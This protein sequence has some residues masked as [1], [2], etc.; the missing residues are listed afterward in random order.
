[1]KYTLIKAIDVAGLTFLT[2]VVR[3]CYRE[4]PKKQ[5]K[6]IGRVI[7][8]PIAAFLVFLM[9]WGVVAPRH[10]TKSGEVPT[11][12][13]VWDAAD[14]IWRFH[15]REGSK[16]DAY[17]LSGK[18]REEKLAI[19]ESHL[20]KL[21]PM[22]DIVRK[23]VEDAESAQATQLAEALAPLVAR[24]DKLEAEFQS[25]RQKREAGLKLSLIHI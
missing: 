3:L 14:S 2:P 1:M 4:E 19:V 9:I 15:N 23:Q 5:M 20:T 8:V 25:A 12:G 16:E 21:R 22:E 24:Y 10:K 17:G 11:P 18:S 6:E 13:V 7:A